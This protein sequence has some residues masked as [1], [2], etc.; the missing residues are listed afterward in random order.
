MGI[1]DDVIDGYDEAK[2]SIKNNLKNT[3]NKLN[4]TKDAAHAA[5]SDTVHYGFSLVSFEQG[6][7]RL[8]IS[9]E[10]EFT[11]RDPYLYQI[12]GK[13]RQNG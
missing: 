1:L 3:K 2:K 11:R 4:K 5:K 10:T 6:M 8:G 13:K 9:R 7:N 12:V